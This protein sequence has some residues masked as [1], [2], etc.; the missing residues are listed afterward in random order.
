MQQPDHLLLLG[1]RRL[2][3]RDDLLLCRS[4]ERAT[5]AA[6]EISVE[7]RGVDVAPAGDRR[8]ITESYGRLPDR[9]DDDASR[10]PVALARL[11]GAQC[12][13]RQDRPFPGPEVLRGERPARGLADV[14][15]HVV[16]P[17]V[18]HLAVVP[19]VLEQLLAGELLAAPDDGRQPPVA[20]ADLVLLPRLPAEPEPDRASVHPR[21]TVAQRGQPE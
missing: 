4:H 8:R 7:D 5:E 13:V 17:D 1:R 18:M 16:G 9:L 15:I 20:Q 14:L 11:E 2:A 19:D 12:P 21:V 3:R 10:R 6:I